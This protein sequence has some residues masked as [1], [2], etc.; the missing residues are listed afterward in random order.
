MIKVRNCFFHPK[1]NLLCHV[2]ADMIEVDTIGIDTKDMDTEEEE[3][4]VS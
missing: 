2:Q 4:N 3:T 1:L